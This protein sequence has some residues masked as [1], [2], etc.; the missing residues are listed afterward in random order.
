MPNPF[1]PRGIG[2]RFVK[3]IMDYVGAFVALLLFSPVMLWAAWRIKQE[4]GGPVF[5]SQK[6]V[7]HNMCPFFVYKFRTMFVG[8][9]AQREALLQN[10]AVRE[11]YEKGAKFKNDPRVTHIGD[12]LRKTSIDELPQLFN[13]LK[14]QMSLVGPRPLL[15]SDV[16]LCYGDEAARIIYSVKPGITGLWQVSGRSDL[17]IHFRRKIN[18]YYVNNWALWRDLGI[19]FRTV[20]VVLSREGAY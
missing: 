16:D 11:E 18:L 1:V 12:F 4:D 5:F 9:D 20:K 8:A 3:P 7:G 19:L 17:N 2:Y 6:R 14:G 13:V 10:E 15:Q